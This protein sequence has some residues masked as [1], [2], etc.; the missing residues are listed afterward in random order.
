MQTT[1]SELE[2]V[3]KKKR[4]RRDRFLATIEEVMPWADLVAVI[5]SHYP[6]GE[7]RGRPPIGGVA[8][9]AH[10]CS[11][12]ML[13]TLRRRHRGRDLRQPGHPSLRRHRP[14]AR[15]RT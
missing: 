4:T 10:V 6:K 13:R 3:G 7:G 15:S 1:F 14:G 8:Y 5:E 12:A 2:Y 11:T 9:S